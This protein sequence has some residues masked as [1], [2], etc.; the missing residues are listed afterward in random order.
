MLK[1]YLDKYKTQEMCDEAVDKILPGLKF[2][3]DWFVTSKMIT[4]TDDALFAN[5]DILLFGEDSAT[6][7]FSSE[8][9]GILIQILIT[10]NL[11]M[12]ILTKMILKLSFMSNLWLELI[13]LNN[14]NHV[15]KI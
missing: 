12:L 13:N 10:L 7:T 11:M 5:D 1:Y 4:K 15:K 8:E 14:A 6:I 2:F 3:L 9:M